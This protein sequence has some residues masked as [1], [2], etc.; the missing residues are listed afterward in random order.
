MPVV[1]KRAVCFSQLRKGLALG[2]IAAGVAAPFFLGIGFGIGAVLLFVAVSVAVNAVG[3]PVLLGGHPDAIQDQA[4]EQPK[5][6]L[7][8]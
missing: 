6:V 8:L 4:P 5:S 2:G 7:G 1:W 3:M